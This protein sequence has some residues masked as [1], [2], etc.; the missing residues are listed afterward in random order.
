MSRE[1][2]VFSLTYCM[3]AGPLE[4]MTPGPLADLAASKTAFLTSGRMRCKKPVAPPLAAISTS[5][6]WTGGRSGPARIMMVP[7]GA[8]TMVLGPVLQPKS[9][10]TETATVLTH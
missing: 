9:V 6:C 1:N 8:W 2:G 10:N 5:G 3:G 7:V 4:S